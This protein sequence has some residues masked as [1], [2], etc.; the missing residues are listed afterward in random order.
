MEP[1]WVSYS[2]PPTDLLLSPSRGSSLQVHTHLGGR[3][4]EPCGV[5]HG[6]PGS[7]LRWE[8]SAGRDCRSRPA[9]WSASPCG[10]AGGPPHRKSCRIRG[11]IGASSGSVSAEREGQEMTADTRRSGGGSQCWTSS[12]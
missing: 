6:A 2:S 10:S 8:S 4:P 1:G 3:S 12:G 5:C 9:P 7:W 11:N